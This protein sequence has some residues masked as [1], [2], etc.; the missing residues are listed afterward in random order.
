[1]TVFDE[2]ENAIE[3]ITH[4]STPG[5]SAGAMLEWIITGL[6]G[7]LNSP[8]QHEQLQKAVNTLTA[9]KEDLS[10]AVEATPTA[11]TNQSTRP[12]PN[13]SGQGSAP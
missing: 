5:A 10:A 7:A 11:T 6:Q 13:R 3:V 9:N 12:T 8:N 4:R 2:V 1:M